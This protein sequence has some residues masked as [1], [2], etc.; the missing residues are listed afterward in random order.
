MRVNIH[1]SIVRMENTSRLVW[2]D[3]YVDELPPRYILGCNFVGEYEYESPFTWPPLTHFPQFD[4][5]YDGRVF[6][7]GKFYIA[8]LVFSLCLYKCLQD[9]R[10][11]HK[12]RQG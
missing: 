4:L 11:L 3:A 9:D 2:R 12:E 7:D 6:K 8:C 1:T 5:E 10:N